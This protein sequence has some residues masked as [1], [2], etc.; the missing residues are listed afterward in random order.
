[1]I[2]KSELLE[3]IREFQPVSTEAVAELTADKWENAMDLHGLLGELQ[4]EGSIVA[5]ETQDE[6]LLSIP[7]GA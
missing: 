2:T 4:R 3:V 5:T 7:E 1:M 6:V